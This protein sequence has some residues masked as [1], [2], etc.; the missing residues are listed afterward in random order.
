MVI[1]KAMVT[2][3]G[4][5]NSVKNDLMQHIKSAQTEISHLKNVERMSLVGAGA[6][7]SR[8][9]QAPSLASHAGAGAGRPSVMRVH[10]EIGMAPDFYPECDSWFKS[11]QDIKSC[12]YCI[13]DWR[14]LGCRKS[15]S[16]QLFLNQ[17]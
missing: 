2:V 14:N 9:R 1:K 17:M 5:L 8:Q 15:S 12:G 3:D 16:V 6:G 10:T 13:D 11:P 7:P 4:K